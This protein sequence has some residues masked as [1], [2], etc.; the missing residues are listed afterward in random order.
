MTQNTK[1]LTS[2]DR[3]VLEALSKYPDGARSYAVAQKAGIRT[4]SPRETAG[5]HLIKITKLGLA[6]SIGTRMFPVWRITEAGRTALAQ[7]EG[8]TR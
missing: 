7:V 6:D 5:R 2:Q 8:E 3:A 4:S 1:T